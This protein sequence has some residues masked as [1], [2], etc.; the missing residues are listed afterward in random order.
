MIFWVLDL[1]PES[2]VSA[3]SFRNNFVLSLINRMIVGFYKASSKILVGSKGFASSIAAKGNFFDKIEYFPNWAENVIPCENIDLGGIRPFE[4]LTADDFVVM[5]AGNLGEA[6]DLVSVINA[7]K[8]TKV[9]QNIKW[10]FLGEGR[11]KESLL[12]LVKEHEL[13]STVFFPGRFPLPF[14]PTLMARAS[15][16]LFSLKNEVIFNVTV[17]SKVQFYM[18][19]SKPIVAMLN[20]DGSSLIDEAQC[21]FNVP[22]G[23]YRRLSEVVITISEM[24]RNVLHELGSNGKKFYERNFRK[25]DRI[26]QL[27]TIFMNQCK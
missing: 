7:A 1:W 23:D 18:S 5:F 17:P 22:A 20:G 16:L 15:V 12:A 21:G 9:H 14:M 8:L 13:E 25:E 19:Q 27:E 10:V 11:K 3:S 2:I 4:E 6:Q 24:N 26:N